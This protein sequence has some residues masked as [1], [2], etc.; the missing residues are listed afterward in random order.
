VPQTYAV[1][2]GVL[3]STPGTYYIDVYASPSCNA[4]GHGE[5]YFWKGTATTTIGPSA[6]S[7]GFSLTIETLGIPTGWPITAT[8]TDATT[9]DSPGNTSEF[10]AC[11]PLAND[12]IFAAEFDPPAV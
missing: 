7:A 4:S 1:V 12:R 11:M 2:K 9:N 8:A 10:S 6:T 3:T 5:G